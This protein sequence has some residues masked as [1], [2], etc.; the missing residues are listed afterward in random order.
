MTLTTKS[1]LFHVLLSCCL[2]LITCVESQIE[3]DLLW[4]KKANKGP[5]R[6]KIYEHVCEFD[7]I[8]KESL[9]FEDYPLNSSDPKI[10]KYKGIT[11]KDIKE[12]G[13]KS[14]EVYRIQVVPVLVGKA[15]LEVEMKNGEKLPI[16]E[17]VIVKP[18]RARDILFD[19]WLW[20]F[21]GLL[22]LIMGLLVEKELIEKMK[23][24]MYKEIGL[25]FVCQYL[26]MPLVNF[27]LCSIRFKYRAPVL[28]V[29]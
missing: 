18:N 8:I 10:F 3:S 22:S 29:L 15:N 16:A 19:V 9:S 2:I 27:L 7:I 13:T 28:T 6:C 23:K 26:I 12:N 17:I 11:L 25:A 4:Y 21:C 14:D 24:E 5:F 20:V 1:K